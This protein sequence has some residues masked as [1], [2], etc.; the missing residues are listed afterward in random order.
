M[1]WWRRRAP[2]P[3]QEASQRQAERAIEVSLLQQEAI[4]E[5]APQIERKMGILARLNRENNFARR[6][7][8]A[9]AGRTEQ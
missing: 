6:L 2:V 7:D 8:A 9:Y 1:S 4:D 5:L 3:D